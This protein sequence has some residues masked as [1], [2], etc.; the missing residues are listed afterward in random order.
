MQSNAERHR[1]VPTVAHNIINKLSTIIGNCDLLI[2]NTEEGTEVQQR[3]AVIREA[4]KTIANEVNAEQ[5]QRKA[6]THK[7][8]RRKAS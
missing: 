2:E 7:K 6:K 3:L 4:A 5:E 8:E 1:N